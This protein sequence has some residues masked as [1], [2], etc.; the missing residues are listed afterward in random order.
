MRKGY[1]K[2]ILDHNIEKFSLMVR[3]DWNMF[4]S[5]ETLTQANQDAVL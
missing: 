1:E 4:S 3:A 2:Q 5:V